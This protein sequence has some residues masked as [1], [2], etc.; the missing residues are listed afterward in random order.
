MRN[1]LFNTARLFAVAA[2]PLALAACE[3]EPNEIAEEPV[4]EA[5]VTDADAAAVGMP[6]SENAENS[7]ETEQP[8][9]GADAVP[10]GELASD[11][12]PGQPI[13]DAPAAPSAE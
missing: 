5:E 1:R 11:A 3:T 12:E 6:E 10:E 13:T 4:E 9:L 8:T 7:A 2:A